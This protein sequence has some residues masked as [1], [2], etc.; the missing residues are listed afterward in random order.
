MGQDNFTTHLC[1]LLRTCTSAT[2][3]LLWLSH[4]IQDRV[5]KSWEP[6]LGTSQKCLRILML[7]TRAPHDFHIWEYG[8][9]G[10]KNWTLGPFEAMPVNSTHQ[11]ECPQ[12][13]QCSYKVSIF[14]TLWAAAAGVP[15]VKSDRPGSPPNL[16]CDFKQV[17]LSLS[18]S[19]LY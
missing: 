6:H 14:C 13:S 15:G 7:R 3:A 11:E 17:S 19:F 5:W 1:H 4:Q 2:A 8:A 9:N 12:P 16:S 10:S 18:L